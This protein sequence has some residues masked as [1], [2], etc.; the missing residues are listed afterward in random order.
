MSD[1]QM[2]NLMKVVIS[3]KVLFWIPQGADGIPGILG[4]PGKLGPTVRWFLIVYIFDIKFIFSVLIFD[5]LTK[6]NPLKEY[7]LSAVFTN[8]WFAE[9][10]RDLTLSCLFP[11]T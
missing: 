8:V 7:S 1:I 2:Q 6:V 4:G 3:L 10:T 9:V 5:Q 11:G